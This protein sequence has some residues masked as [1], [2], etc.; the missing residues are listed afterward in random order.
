MI[1][2]IATIV[3]PVRKISILEDVPDNRILECATA[4]QAHLIVTGDRHLLKLREFEGIS[5]VRLVDFL[6]TVPS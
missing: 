2:R 4:A 1:G 3:R 5:I 6:R